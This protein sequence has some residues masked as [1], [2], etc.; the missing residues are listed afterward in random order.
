M[1][2]T[3]NHYALAELEA[4][5]RSEISFTLEGFWDGGFSWW[6]GPLDQSKTPDG[7]ADTFEE[8]IVDLCNAAR[9]R[10]P[11]S[12]YTRG[13]PT[14]ISL[15]PPDRT[16]EEKLDDLN[17]RHGGPAEI[18]YLV[19]TDPYDYPWTVVPHGS[20]TGYA[21]FTLGDALDEALTRSTPPTQENP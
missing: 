2:H 18:D 16:N 20:D 11:L 21:G 15:R 9:T 17:T 4:M 1:T 8:A 10:Y 7:H 5:Y 3:S 6:F 14:D 19:T 13:R 12:D